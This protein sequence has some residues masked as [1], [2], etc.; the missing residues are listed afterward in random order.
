VIHDALSVYDAYPDARH[1]LCCAHYP[2]LRIIRP[3]PVP[4]WWAGVLE[5]V[6][7]G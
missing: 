4:R 7:S 1:A 5:Q 3:P 6:W 2:D